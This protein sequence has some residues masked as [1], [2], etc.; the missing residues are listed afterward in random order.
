MTIKKDLKHLISAIKKG[1]YDA[2]DLIEKLD[3][4]ISDVRDTKFTYRTQL[5]N[6]QRTSHIATFHSYGKQNKYKVI[7]LLEDVQREM[8]TIQP[9]N[10]FMLWQLNQLIKTGFFADKL[11]EKMNQETLTRG[12]AEPQRERIEVY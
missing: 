12:K 8:K 5:A 9:N 7:A 6:E 2:S 11:Q 10:R 1:K 3:V 4:L